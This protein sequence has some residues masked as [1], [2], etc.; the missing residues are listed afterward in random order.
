M[1]KLIIFALAII[2]IPCSC[3]NVSTKENLIAKKIGTGDTPLIV[4]EFDKLNDT[5]SIPLSSLV[6]SFEYVILESGTEAF[7]APGR[8]NI[9]ENYIF[10]RGRG[11]EN[12]LSVKRYDKKTGKFLNNIGSYGRGPFEYRN[13]Y[14]IEVDEKNNSVYIL[15]WQSY[16]LLQFTLDGMPVREIPLSYYSAKGVFKINPD[17]TITMAVLPFPE[18]PYFIWQQDVEGNLLH[19]IDAASFTDERMSYSNE[20][21]SNG[22]ISGVNEIYQFNFM[23]KRDSIYHYDY[24]NHVLK[25]VFTVD[26]GSIEELPVHSYKELPNHFIG[27]VTIMKQVGPDTWSGETQ[28]QYIVDKATLK[29][30]YFKLKDDFLGDEQIYPYFHDGYYIRMQEPEI[31]I[32]KLKKRLED[33]GLK[34][35]VRERIQALYG[36]LDPEGNSVVFLGKLKQ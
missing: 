14:D 10:V 36:S 27:D 26:Y 18:N 17:N 32:E 30:N 1:K 3:N 16:K 33:K 31:L 24:K 15:P 21:H 19:G 8:V 25:P 4:M 13:I 29:G 2:M 23:N 7:V 22:N 6:E 9:S 5:L 12:N 20:M 34:D 28:V 11:S 35:E